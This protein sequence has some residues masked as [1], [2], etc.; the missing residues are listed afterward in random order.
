MNS[1][2]VNMPILYPTYFNVGSYPIEYSH[3]YSFS[4][5]KTQNEFSEIQSKF[6]ETFKP[7]SDKAAKIFKPKNSYHSEK[8]PPKFS[9][10]NNTKA[11]IEV[12][13]EMPLYEHPSTDHSLIM[14]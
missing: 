10:D 9:L 12:N 6:Q 7:F 2:C 1:S 8:A 11:K 13:N 14:A 5:P 4:Y 3:G